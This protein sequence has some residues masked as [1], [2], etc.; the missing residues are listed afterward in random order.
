VK[1]AEGSFIAFAELESLLVAQRA[2][3][4][5]DE[6]GVKHGVD[7]LGAIQQRNKALEQQVSNAHQS[8][9]CT[10]EL[11]LLIRVDCTGA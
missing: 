2:R 9:T 3:V 5:A 1:Q 4:Y 10:P 6:L 8:Y 7:Q 11:P